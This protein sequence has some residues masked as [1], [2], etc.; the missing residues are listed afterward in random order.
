MSSDVSWGGRIKV[1][2]EKNM[3]HLLKGVSKVKN[4]GSTEMENPEHIVLIPNSRSLILCQ[5]VTEIV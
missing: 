3:D 4:N 1:G 5:V 2:D